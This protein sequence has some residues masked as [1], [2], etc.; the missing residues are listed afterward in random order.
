MNDFEK[1]NFKT[2]LDSMTFS[3]NFEDETLKLLSEKKKMH[4]TGKI[5]KISSA[6]AVIAII[7]SVSAFALPKLL[8]SRQVAER[9]KMTEI[10]ELFESEN[11]SIEQT[12]NNGNLILTLH[13]A[14]HGKELVNINGIDVE[15]DR[16]YFVVSVF[17][18]DGKEFDMS[19]NEIH[20]TPLVKG[21]KVHEV[22]VCSLG[23]SISII[24]E[25]GVL[26]YLINTDTLK[27]FAD[28]EVYLAAY[29]GM[30]PF[31]L[32]VSNDDGSF[33]YEKNYDGVKAIFTLP[34][35]YFN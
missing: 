27:P 34:S 35:D 6:V 15:E 33:G 22:N 32:I 8:T 21:Y 12:I 31:G 28:R 18:K 19:K 7:M 24:Q 14:V 1:S 13:S 2:E 5:I 16:D 17:S 25:N 4:K 3:P 26:Y 9:L 30:M 23:T 11:A 29:D 20:F 10:G